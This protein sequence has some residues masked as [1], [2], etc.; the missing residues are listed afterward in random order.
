M[1]PLKI[2][3]WNPLTGNL[4]WFLAAFFVALMMGAML[5]RVPMPLLFVMACA[6]CYFWHET[7]IF[8]IDRALE[9][10]PFLV[11]GMW[12]GPRY[13]VIE[14][15][16]PLVS[17]LLAAVLGVVLYF[18]IPHQRFQHDWQFI[19]L[20]LLGTAMLLLLGRAM[21]QGWLARWFAWIGVASLGVFLLSPFGQGAG[22][23]VLLRMHVRQPVAQLVL[24]TVVAVMIPAW[25][26]QRRA[27]LR[28][29]WMFAWP[30]SG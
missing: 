16:A 9:F 12:V 4:D 21:G 11:A 13:G 2:V 5:S 17:L 15:L 27:K 7:G 26:Y 6:G 30:F 20:G 1:P 19:P 28:L 14:K 22:R 18:A 3:L 10:M 24:P 25:L 8:S 29:G 23:E